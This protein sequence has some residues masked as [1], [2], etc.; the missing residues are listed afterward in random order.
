MN[1]EDATPKPKP[2][3]YVSP[4]NDL[5]FKRIFGDHPEL[6]KSFLNALLP[7][8]DDAPID[9]L[10]YINPEQVPESPWRH[11]N[12][13]VDVKCRD[14][15]GRL[16]LVEMQM[17]WSGSFQKRVLFGASH[18]YV[19]QLK[20]S[21]NYNVL[22]PVY[23]LALTNQAFVHN[24]PRYHHHYKIV[25]TEDTHQVIQ[26]MEFVFVE[27]PKFKPTTTLDKRMTVLWMRFMSEVGTQDTQTIDQELLANPLIEQA[28]KITERASL[29]EADL[30][31]YHA[32]EDKAR[33][34][35]LYAIDARKEGKAEGKA[36]LIKTMH[37]NGMSPEKISLMTG[38]T[39]D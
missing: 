37:A 38:H 27:I 5:I 35:E 1:T 15:R 33:V 11:K 7:L 31:I 10:E 8:P 23:A 2:T 3:R 14:A 30:E 6:L 36:E 4:R 29:S 16:F 20:V 39:V 26:G 17:L 32:C 18:A 12:S 13:I 9:T 28:L 24:S 25:C 34:D 22:E 19:K 21:E